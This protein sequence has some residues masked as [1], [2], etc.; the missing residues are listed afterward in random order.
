VRG[1]F[2]AAVIAVGLAATLQYPF[3]GVLL[4]TWFTCMQ[5]HEEAY[6]FVQTAPLNLIIA[7]VTILAWLAS[8]ESKL[9]RLDAAFVLILLFLVWITVNGFF[10]VNPDYSWPYWN[11]TWK[12][13]ALGVFVLLLTT[14]RVR[15][16]TLI[17]VV[18]VSLLY[19]GIKGGIFTIVT[20]GHNHVVGP[21][22]SIIGDNNQ[23]ALALL[24]VLPL[25]NYL[26]VQ[27]V[28]WRIK[29]GLALSMVL[30]LF[31]IL[32]S[33]SRGAFLALGALAVVAW[34]RSRNKIIYV[35]IVGA[36]AA[37][38]FN[39]MPRE[40]FARLNSIQAA[41][42]DESFSGRV[43]A[44]KVALDYAKEHFPFG[45]GFYES[46]QPAI[47][48]H[49]FPNEATHA[50]H[51]IY[52]EVLGDNGFMGLALYLGI[53]VVA[54]WNTFKIRRMTKRRPELSWAHDLAGM[55]QLSLF[56]FCV[57]G[58]ALSMA[59]YD[60]FFILVGLLSAMITLIERQT[61]VATE[62]PNPFAQPTSMVTAAN[63]SAVA[64]KTPT[65]FTKAGAPR[66]AQ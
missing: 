61:K 5:P 60:V 44:W 66:T 10:A 64:G 18:V 13:I 62:A 15:A 42:Q 25:T 28:D 48:N 16:H 58:A 51:S 38:A 32:G 40:Y 12:T 47:F 34:L 30:V 57:G 8:K 49:Y 65:T 2:L 45:D 31:A 53:L 9:P 56:V 33:Y 14:N 36:V 39:F 6:G 52:F 41:D 4:W 59:Y 37:L 50:A 27:S 22:N 20:G 21:P 63:S 29:L 26:R 35:V 17:W 7:V 24:M 55:T 1:L 11:V 3:S 54:F 43:M 46:Q 19:Y 23:L